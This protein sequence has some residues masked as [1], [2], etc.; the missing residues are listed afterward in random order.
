MFELS[1]N[2]HSSAPRI[3]RYGLGGVTCQVQ[4]GLAQQGVVTG[5]VAKLALGR[6]WDAREPLG[7]L[8]DDLLDN[9]TKYDPL[10]GK[11]QGTRKFQEF[12]HYVRKRAGLVQD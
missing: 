9:R 10:T 7:D 3:V 6:D 11:I 4:Y 8:S 5:N 1:S 12:G 2:N